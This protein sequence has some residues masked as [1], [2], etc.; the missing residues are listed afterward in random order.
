MIDKP[1]EPAWLRRK[2]RRDPIEAARG[3][4]LREVREAAG[5]GFDDDRLKQNARQAAGLERMAAAAGDVAT[6]DAALDEAQRLAAVTASRRAGSIGG[7]AA[8]LALLV[9]DM[10]ADAAAGGIDRSE[11][12]RLLLAAS[13]LAD[14]TLI[15]DAPLQLP[16]DASLPIEDFADVQRIRRRGGLS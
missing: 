7:I 11:S 12:L 2:Y 13:A 4:L 16:D 10:V 9:G 5:A 3:E 8:K 6:R 15:G 14:A 1:E